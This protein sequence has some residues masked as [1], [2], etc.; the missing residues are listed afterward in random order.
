MIFYKEDILERFLMKKL[1]E[2]KNKPHRKPL[3]LN[4]AGE[5]GKTWL[6]NGFGEAGCDPVADVSLAENPAG[7]TIQRSSSF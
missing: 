5:V 7:R 6:L 2:W 4:G 1:I 3:I